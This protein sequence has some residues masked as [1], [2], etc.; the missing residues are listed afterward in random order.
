MASPQDLMVIQNLVRDAVKNTEVVN[1]VWIAGAAVIVSL[2]A[3]LVASITQMLVAG[4]Q[5][6]TQL[7]LAKEQ[8][9]QQ[10]QALSEQ[11]SMQELA[12]RRIANANIAAKRQVWIDELRKEVAKYLSIWQEISYRWDAIVSKPG[13]EGMSEDALAAFSL[14]IAE[15]RQ[16]ALEIQLRMELRLNMTETKHREL[17]VLMKTLEQST[18][19]FQRTVSKFPARAIQSVFQ[20]ISRDIVVKTQEILKEEWERVKRESYADPTS[21]V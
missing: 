6:K 21:S 1:K 7:R 4:W 3:A 14:P 18:V 10:K 12:S 15:M 5:R 20:K 9:L 13:K 17:V 19:L 8:A 16:E 11:L 2:F